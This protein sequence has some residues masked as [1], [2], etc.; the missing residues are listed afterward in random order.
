MFVES[1][2]AWLLAQPVS[3]YDRNEPVDERRS[4]LSDVALAIDT[5]AEGDRMK[6]AFLAVQADR[7]SGLRLD[8]EECRCPAK[9]CDKGK[10]RGLWQL[11]KA[12][13]SP[14]VWSAICSTDVE[15]QTIAA[16]W[17]LRFYSGSLECSFARMGGVA[18]CDVP[19]AV[20]RARMVR[21]LAK[22][23]RTR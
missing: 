10:A 14:E 12:P 17:T 13:D 9:Q 5:A 23:W 19:W 1:I 18:R 20:E 2:L 3:P 8:V 4:R 6:A 22:K 7:E 21:E 16:R 15:A 11:H